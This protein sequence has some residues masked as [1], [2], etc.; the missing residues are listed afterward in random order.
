MLL[1]AVCL[2][3]LGLIVLVLSSEFLVKALTNIAICLDLNEFVIGFIIVAFATSIPELIIGI[4]SAIDEIPSLSLGNVIGANIIDLTLVIGIVTVLKRGIRIETKTVKTDS[5]YMFIIALLP[6]I[7]MLDGVLTRMDGIMLLVVFFLYLWRLFNQERRFKERLSSTNMKKLYPN[8]FIA[9]ICIILLYTSAKFV[10]ES[11]KTIAENYFGVPYMLIGLFM[12][13]FG[14]TLPELTFETRAI[15]MKHK[16]MA[17][18]DLIG[19]VITNSSFVLGIT[20][21]ICPINADPIIFMTSAFFLVVVSFLFMTFV[22]AERHI[23][24]QEG[25]ALILLYIL[26]MIVELNLRFLNHG[27]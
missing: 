1:E 21:I 15:F 16:Y 24:W 3:I 7:L 11:S 2:L 6:L 19:S 23:L 18:G 13:S 22:E 17:L 14:T 8:I 20:A 26:F 27:M 5:F 12:I 9:I 25:I 10:V 4:N